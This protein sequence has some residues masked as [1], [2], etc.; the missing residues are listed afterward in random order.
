MPGN[1]SLNL[2]VR[3]NVSGSPRTIDRFRRSQDGFNRAVGGGQREV[4]RFNRTAAAPTT[5]I[6]YA[7]A[8][9]RRPVIPRL[10]GP[11]SQRYARVSSSGRVS[12]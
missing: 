12:V 10:S 11:S 1:R 4:G 8:S 2:E 7:C 6:T 9:T 3:V 5:R